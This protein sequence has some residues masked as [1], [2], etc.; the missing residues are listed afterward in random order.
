M[1]D[2]KQSFEELTGLTSIDCAKLEH[3]L[4][5]IRNYTTSDVLWLLVHTAMFELSAAYSE[6][7]RTFPAGSPKVE[8]YRQLAGLTTRVEKAVQ[9]RIAGLLENLPPVPVKTL[10]AKFEKLPLKDSIVPSSYYLKSC[11][12]NRRDIVVKI[13]N[14][15]TTIHPG[16]QVIV[17]IEDVE[18]VCACGEGQIVRWQRLP[19]LEPKTLSKSFPLPKR[20]P[21]MPAWKAWLLLGAMTIGVLACL[22]L[23]LL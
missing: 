14:E 8:G 22:S 1:I 19:T 20:R 11:R 10:S 6:L 15:P 21:T 18:S 23:L 9:K 4:V 13:N 7:A 16:G 3:E 2:L 12:T 17:R 5:V